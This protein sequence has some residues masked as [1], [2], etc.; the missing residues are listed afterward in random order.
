MVLQETEG[1]TALVVDQA[2]QSDEHDC[3]YLN[4]IEQLLTRAGSDLNRWTMNAF[5]RSR[6]AALHVDGE[7]PPTHPGGDMT[8]PGAAWADHVQ[9]F[10]SP[11]TVI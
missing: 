4:H 7:C 10:S 6:I 3:P 5:V 11:R 2:V 9:T 8:K 1:T